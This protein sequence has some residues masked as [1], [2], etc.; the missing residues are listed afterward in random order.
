MH[1]TQQKAWDDKSMSMDKFAH[2]QLKKKKTKQTNKWVEVVD[3]F[4]TLFEIL[5]K[6]AYG[7]SSWLKRVKVAEMTLYQA[8][9]VAAIMVSDEAYI[10]KT[11]GEKMHRGKWMFNRFRYEFKKRGVD[12]YLS[13]R[14]NK[15]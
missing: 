2:I 1:E 15:K 8:E 14:V 6:G 7:Y 9:K 10:L 4:K 12:G 5:D 3:L 11:K 13:S